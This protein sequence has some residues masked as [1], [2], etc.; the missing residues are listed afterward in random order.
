MAVLSDSTI[1]KGYLIQKTSCEVNEGGDTILSKYMSIFKETK[2][3]ESGHNILGI[4][5]SLCRCT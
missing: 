5:W 4:R 1:N 3:G 2:D